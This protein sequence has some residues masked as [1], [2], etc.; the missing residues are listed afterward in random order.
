[1]Q[2]DKNAFPFKTMCLIILE[3]VARAQKK[4]KK[5]KKKEYGSKDPI[6]SETKELKLNQS[7][8]FEDKFK[9]CRCN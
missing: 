9:D 5:K 7:N 1:M 8:L 6:K 2:N 4:K 3:E